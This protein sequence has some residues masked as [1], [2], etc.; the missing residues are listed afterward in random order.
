M[1]EWSISP[2]FFNSALNGNE[3]S[4]SCP[5]AL[6]SGKWPPVIDLIGSWV[7]QRAGFKA[8]KKGKILL[9]PGSELRP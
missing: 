1:K 3:W 4:A 9:L 5:T 6:H 2:V 7:G 8:V